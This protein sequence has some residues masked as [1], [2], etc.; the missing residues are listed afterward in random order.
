ME[1]I[2]PDGSKTTD[3]TE[4][5]IYSDKYQT[6]FNDLLDQIVID[7]LENDNAFGE[8]KFY[9]RKYYYAHEN[10]ES[11]NLPIDHLHSDYS[12]WDE[13]HHYKIGKKENI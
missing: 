12:G 1:Y 9:M 10:L 8:L 2:K 13:D 6:S 3:I 5:K 11:D 7:I 4:I